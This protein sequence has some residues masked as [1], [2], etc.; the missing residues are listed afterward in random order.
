MGKTKPWYLEMHITL[1]KL[2]LK[3]KEVITAK[4]KT[5]R[6]VVIGRDFGDKR[7]KLYFLTTIVMTT[8]FTMP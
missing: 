5:V 3:Y 8:K 2:F 6:E 4:V 7:Q 1:V